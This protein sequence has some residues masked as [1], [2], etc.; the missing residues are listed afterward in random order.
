LFV[1]RLVN[2]I[3]SPESFQKQVEA[4]TALAHAA[5]H[6]A[7]TNGNVSHQNEQSVELATAALESFLAG[8]GTNN[9][10]V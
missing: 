7:K 2:A 9:T 5:A 3:A 10:K 1:E 4:V 8:Y 6:Q